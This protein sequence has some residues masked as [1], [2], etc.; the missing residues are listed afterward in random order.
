MINDKLI[1][2]KKQSVISGLVTSDKLYAY[3]A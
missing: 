2:N 3:T 1:S